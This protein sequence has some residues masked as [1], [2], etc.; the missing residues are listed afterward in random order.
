MYD[1]IA[2]WRALLRSSKMLDAH[3]SK[4][5]VMNIYGEVLCDDMIGLTE[6]AME[7]MEQFFELKLQSK[8]ILHKFKKN[9]LKIDAETNIEFE[10]DSEDDNGGA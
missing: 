10:S 9:Y 4:G 6:N 5:V 7:L 3:G 1:E 8:N 2:A